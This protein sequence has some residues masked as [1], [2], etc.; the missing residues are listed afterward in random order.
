M[1]SL[2]TLLGQ[3][4]PPSLAETDFPRFAVRAVG[5]RPLSEMP[6]VV[7]ALREDSLTG[8]PPAVAPA[9]AVFVERLLAEKA[10]PSTVDVE[11]AAELLGSAEGIEALGRAITLDR[12]VLRPGLAVSIDVRD[13]LGDRMSILPGFGGPL[14]LLSPVVVMRGHGIGFASVRSPAIARPMRVE[15]AQAIR[16]AWGGLEEQTGWPGPLGHLW[17]ARFFRVI[18]RPNHDLEG[19][20]A[21][22]EPMPSPARRALWT[23]IVEHLRDQDLPEE[24]RPGD[25]GLQKRLA[26]AEITAAP[27]GLQPLLE[28]AGWFFDR[29]GTTDSAVDGHLPLSSDDLA[30]WTSW[31]QVPE[32]SRQR[33]GALPVEE[34]ERALRAVAAKASRR[35][36]PAVDPTVA[37]DVIAFR[38]EYLR[39]RYRREV[40]PLR[41]V[42]P[43]DLVRA[44]REAG[45]DARIIVRDVRALA[46]EVRRYCDAVRADDA[47]RQR[48]AVAEAAAAE[49]QARRVAAAEAEAAQEEASQIEAAAR[50]IGVSAAAVAE[51]D[52]DR[53]ATEIIPASARRAPKEPTPFD[54]LV[55]PKPRKPSAPLDVNP[56]AGED[57]VSKSNPAHEFEP[58]PPGFLPPLPVPPPRKRPTTRRFELPPLPE[59]PPR[60][61]HARPRTAELSAV[62]AARTRP[63]TA[64]Q[65]APPV[66][67]PAA[68]TRLPTG[69][70][71]VPSRGRPLTEETIEIPAPRARLNTR[72]SGSRALSR[73]PTVPTLG[74][75]AAAALRAPRDTRLTTPGQAT[76]F[77]EEAFRELEVFE[78]DLLERGSWPEVERRVRELGKDADALAAALGP[79]ARSGDPA[80]QTALKK[81]ELVRAYLERITPLM[82]G[83]LPPDDDDPPPTTMLGRLG[84]FLGRGD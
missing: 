1:F 50:E 40:E 54:G 74:A 62:P 3:L 20:R 45:H 10:E 72:D 75:A 70:A 22:L 28:L 37:R 30:V 16:D 41:G 43:L 18:A 64:E 69:D 21:L 13:F 35:A 66:A 42:D 47:K 71:V 11:R 29:L 46:D 34:V 12:S 4:P 5:K 65:P 32:A 24:H 55:P 67:P 84:R 81:V 9:L 31:V 27:E 6:R 76:A 23:A 73:P 60:T 82:H 56:F 59:P 68:R 79:P 53:D 19:C 33:L 26:L 77:Y 63:P 80:F 25:R 39:W 58:P 15:E 52:G 78:R 2:S 7:D 48:E 14:A 51:P 38:E 49:K 8:Y 57:R 61:S 36:Q 44:Q 83:H 17:E